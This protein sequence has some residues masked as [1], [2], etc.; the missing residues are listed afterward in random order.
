MPIDALASKGG[1][2]NMVD[3]A[4]EGILSPFLRRQRFKAAAPHLGGKVLDVGC[5]TGGLASLVEPEDYV[6][7]ERDEGSLSVARIAFPHHRFVRDPAEIGGPF[8]TIVGL[9]IIEHVPD[10]AEFLRSLARHLRDA[11]GSRIICTTPHPSVDWLHYVGARLGIFSRHA[12]D[13]HEDLLDR[14]ILDAVSRKAGLKMTHYQ[15]FLFGV[16]QLAIFERRS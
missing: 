2:R 9:A 15:R 1:P 8:D 7:V 3:Q 11:A 6:G 10:P 14:G 4:S 12:N 13:E 5:G 16:N